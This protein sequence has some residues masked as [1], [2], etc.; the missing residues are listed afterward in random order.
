MTRMLSLAIPVVAMATMAACGGDDP[1]SP[2][3]ATA[4]IQVT[5]ARAA[6]EQMTERLEAGGTVAAGESAL[7]S[8]RVVAPI[9]EVRVTAGDQV[10]RG[11]VLVVLDARDVADHARQARAGADAAE[12][13]LQQ[14]RAARAAAEAERKLAHAW[15]SR[16][17]ALHSR[18]S[19]TAQELDEAEARL[20]GAEARLASAGAAISA[21]QANI[22]AAQAA[23]GAATTTESFTIIRAPF[24]GLITER[25]ND[26]GNLAAPGTPL[27][28]IESLGERRVEGTIDEARV[29]FISPGDRVEVIVDD[30][31]AVKRSP[32][33]GTVS[34]I[35]RAMA[36]DQR[37]FRVKVLLP[38]G[39]PLRTGTFARIRFNGPSRQALAI[40]LNAVQRH[41]QLTSVFVVEDGLARVR[42]LQ[43][44]TANEN[45]VEVLAGL[46][47][48]EVVV[49]SPP[50][51]LADAHAVTTSGAAPG[52]GDRP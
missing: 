6:V 1:E 34:E 46:D 41:G 39:E 35:A 45:T 47:A 8:S 12:H 23:S 18:N 43:L 25:L 3:R 20:A 26:P 10:R 14:A 52:K 5:T 40:P 17:A 7:I 4:A 21:A 32:I 36:A 51:Q 33:V 49:T 2:Q 24:D 27:V 48:G 42:M 28:R 15:H 50:P 22:V 9:L 44:G 38:R 31:S 11:D 13:S 29:S 16:I 30:N 19:A 37:A